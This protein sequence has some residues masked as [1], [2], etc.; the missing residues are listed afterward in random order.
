M[1]QGAH[2][3]ANGAEYGGDLYLD[4]LL[5]CW[6]L[7]WTDFGLRCRVLVEKIYI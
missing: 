4:I 3:V 7:A 1:H 5:R 6:M 2:L